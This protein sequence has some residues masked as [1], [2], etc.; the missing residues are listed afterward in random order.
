VG[1]HAAILTLFLGGLLLT[2]GAAGTAPEVPGDPTPPVVTPVISGTLG[3][4]G[5]YVTTVT[6]SWSIVDPESIILS[7]DGCDTKTFAA[8]TTGITLTCKAESDGGITTVSKTFKVDKTAPNA[9]AGPDRSADANGWY[10]HSLTVG[11]SGTDATSGLDA[12]SSPKTYAGPD[13]ANATVTG[14]CTDKAGN[15]APTSLGLKYDATAPQNNGGSPSRGADANGWYNHAF[16]VTF[17]GS[18]V[19]SGVDSCTEVTYSGPD[20]PSTSVSGSCRDIAGNQSGSKTFALKYDETDP[21]VTGKS[22]S[23]QPDSKGW[24][25]HA[26]TV[27][28]SGSDATSGVDACTQTTYAG[29]DAVAAS[30][31]GTCRD[32]A[33]NE[34]GSS[35]L[36]L[37]YDATVPQVNGTPSRPTDANGWYNHALSVSFGGSDATSG[38]DACVPAQ[39]YSGPDSAT[40]SVSGTCTDNAGNTGS[41][42]VAL[43]YDQTAPG[44]TPAP[45]RSPDANGWYNHSLSV[46]FGGSDATS[47]VDTCSAPQSYSGPDSATASVS[48]SCSD[49]AGNSTP[50]SFG[51]KYDATNPQVTAAPSR[52]ADSN[53]WYNHA[54]TVSF[55]GADVT[56]GVGSCA[57][58]KSYSAP[59]SASASVSGS[60]TDVAGNTGQQTL[61]FKYD[62]TAPNVTGSTPSRGADANG[63]YNHALTVGF[64]GSDAT[65]GVD[66]CTQAAYSGPDSASASVSGT[67]KDKAANQSL[68]STFGLKYDATAP[69]VSGAAPSRGPD[70][71]GWY[72]HALTVGFQGSDAT[73][74]VDA[75]TQVGYSGPDSATASVTGTCSDK[76]A[77]QSTSSTFGLKYD[78]TV[79]QVTATPS[80]PVDANGWYNHALTVTFAGSDATSQ[81]DSCEAPKAYSGPD[82]G[83]ASVSGSCTDK[84]GNTG[85][86]SLGLKY[87]ATDPQAS[88]SPSRPADANGWHNHALSV[89]FSGSDVTSGIASCDAPEN[90]SGPDTP[91]AVVT[92]TCL[93]VAGNDGL[94][95]LAVKYDATQPA[96]TATPSRAVDANGWYNH[97]LTVSFGG[98]DL[99]SG[100]G[101]CV[102]PKKYNTP[103]SATASVTGSCTDVAGNSGSQSLGF[104]YDQTAPQVTGSTP[105]RVADSN[106]WYNHAL[107]VGF[108][109][110]DAT[111]GVDSCTQ[112]AYSGPDSETASV[113]GS[114]RDKAANQSVTSTFALKYDATPP[115]MAQPAP[116]R[117]PD[118]N[119][120]YNHALSVTFN[121]QDAT[122]K[123]DSCVPPQGYSGPDRTN[124]SVGGTCRDLAGNVS[125]RSF[126]FGYD[127]TAPAGVAAA[128]A[129]PPDENGWYNGA[130]TIDF[131]GDDATSGLDACSRLTYGGPDSSTAS[132]TGSCRDR[133]GNTSASSSFGFKYDATEPVVTGAAALRPPDHADWYNRPVAFTVQGNDG[134]AGIESCPQA[135]YG[136]PDGADA[137]VDGACFDKAG[138]RGSKAFP[139]RYDAAGPAVVVA[140]TRPPDRN[141]WYNHAVEVDLSG[142]DA[143]AGLE[144]C[145]QPDDYTGPDNGSAAGVGTCFD[146]AGNVGAGTLALRYDAT[147]PQLT[148]AHADRQADANGWYNRPLAVEFS[149]VDPVSQVEACTRTSYGGPDAASVSLSGSCRD[150]AGNESAAGSFGLRYDGSAPTVGRLKV[151]AGNR[152]AV[153]SWTASDDT[154]L[155]EVARSVVGRA[156]QRVVYRGAGR[157]FTDTQLENGVRYRWRLTGYDEARNEAS[158]SAEALPLA[159]LY[160]PAAGAKVVAPPLLAWKAV[161]KATYY[162]VQLWRHRRILSAWPG[163]T[164]LRL[165]RSWSYNGRRYR[166]EP[167]RYRW[168]V[169]PGLGPRAAKKYGRLIGSSTFEV[170]APKRA[171]R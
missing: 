166:L 135:V 12:C 72:N 7:T 125:A 60:C 111:S 92:G 52:V 8:D 164:S 145:V 143:V 162:N 74:G 70:A 6:V 30:V 149:G 2:P 95:A 130:V 41:R 40:A 158:S 152:S 124:A 113:P 31:P 167:G 26:V 100:L 79:P 5:W 84:A 17:S 171:T 25:N 138:N 55:A 4:N 160:G 27:T 68:S 61:G 14:S 65:S 133:A 147:A 144:S 106:G 112:A 120:W 119:G 161:P 56:S 102:Q 62:Q 114:C 110:S 155:V 58:P 132:A 23:R 75:C 67:C 128:P 103:D 24:Y 18:D 76:A 140:A 57:A 82:N 137:A 53:G 46:S 83:N 89:N 136:G 35:A 93:D 47:G 66:S 49:K 169:W 168:Y 1:R 10:N 44:V 15:S 51:L 126:A 105:S 142:S 16:T 170:V 151:T 77:N 29:P 150:R 104:K 42:S 122:S 141:G 86:R 37:A 63:W 156:G 148:G 115:V 22:P 81:V 129:R 91:N 32:R 64:Q 38:V 50:K 48:G 117:D 33:G 28:F 118:A 21:A 107:T 154:S 163:S 131:T 165:P 90:Y 121:G 153:L 123:L 80:R 157:T 11:F 9:S 19:T 98:S 116:S 3:L 159:P 134:T 99:T 146:R 71:N 13:S 78:A 88:A 85:T 94:A 59:D 54:L 101:S 36:T 109:G 139:L 34:S 20:D 127:A 73:S 43:K 108:Q 69:V 45:A 96:V 87:D 39:S 97:E